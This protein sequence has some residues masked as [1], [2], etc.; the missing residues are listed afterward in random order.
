MVAKEYNY[1]VGRRKETSAVMKLF[2]K[3]K[4]EFTVRLSSGKTLPLKEYFGGNAHLYE[5]AIMPLLILGKEYA[6]QFDAEIVVKGG[7]VSGQSDAIKLAFARALVDRNSDFRLQLKPY[8]LLKRDP[9]IKERK[10]PGLKKARKAPT[11]SKR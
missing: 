6:T 3:G 7:G 11:W 5:N 9:R 4:G 10:K 2:P 8:G 1:A